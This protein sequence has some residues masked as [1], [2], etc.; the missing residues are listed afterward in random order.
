MNCR[1][2]QDRSCQFV[3]AYNQANVSGV[4]A[5]AAAVTYL[6]FLPRWEDDDLVLLGGDRDKTVTIYNLN[7]L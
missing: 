3:A 5:A 1:E 2:I 7:D 6:H 4:E